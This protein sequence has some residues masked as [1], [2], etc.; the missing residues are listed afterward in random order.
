MAQTAPKPAPLSPGH[1]AGFVAIAGKPNAGKSTLLNALVGEKLA[2][3]TPKASTTRHR[4]AGFLSEENYQLVLVDTPGVIIPKYKLH[5]KMMETVSREL[6]AADA[7]LWLASADEQFPEG[8]VIERLRAVKVPII[9]ALNK[10]DLLDESTT[11]ARLNDLKAQVPLA[12][13]VAVSALQQKGLQELVNLLVTHMPEAPPYYDKEDLTDLPMRFLAAELVR[14]KIFLYTQQE[15]PYSSQ[16]DVVLYSEQPDRVHIEMDVHVERESQKGIL[17]GK[18]GS[19]LQRI[20]TEARMELEAFLGQ[21]VV[22]KLHIRV[23]PDWKDRESN[24]RSFGYV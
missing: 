12:G 23:T 3:V 8:E 9:L 20:G 11:E 18:Q 6:K 10:A 5:E 13:A 24:L 4:I 22:L 15:V 17:I 16:V 7:V 19:M 21:K 2:I 1:R 14:E